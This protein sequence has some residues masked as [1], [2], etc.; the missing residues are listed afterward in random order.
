MNVTR[1][2]YPWMPRR[3][4]HHYGRLYG[5]RV[6]DV[7]RGAT[8]LEDLGRHFGGELYEAEAR[9]LVAREW[10]QAADDILYRRTK[11]YLHL[12][13]AECADFAAWF[14][15]EHVAAQAA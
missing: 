4:A 9:Y 14:E 11:H 7:V 5:T 8:R 3:L 15:A 6:R 2:T 10:A 12:S 1:G 13:E